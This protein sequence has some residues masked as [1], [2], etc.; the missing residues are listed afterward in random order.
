MK[1]NHI[2]ILILVALAAIFIL[3]NSAIVTI[4]LFFWRISMNQIIMIGGLLITGF[5]IGYLLAR[6]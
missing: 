5:L 4:K 2:L 1:S 3:Q 6:R